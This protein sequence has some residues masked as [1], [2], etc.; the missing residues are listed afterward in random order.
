MSS[1]LDPTGKPLIGKREI[2]GP[3][4]RILYC[5]VCKSIEELPPHDGPAET[6]VLLELAVEKHEFPSGER[7]VGKL[8][9]LPVKM[10]MEDKSRKAI[11][12]QMRESAGQ[13]VGSGEGLNSLTEDKDY[14]SSKS[15]FGED[16]MT[17]WKA[18]LQ[19]KDGC[20]EYMDEGKRLIPKTDIER[21]N[22]GLPT[23]RESGINVF[24]CPFCPV[25]SAV[26]TRKRML[27]GMYN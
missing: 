8:F 27:M 26:T 21:K 24:L 20:G 25:H 11:I 13:L 18:H 14:Y 12:H 5:L 17:C 10:W 3:L 1:L 23:S 6:D 2:E 16:A 9:I 7:H 15:Q 22:L 4:I 19:P